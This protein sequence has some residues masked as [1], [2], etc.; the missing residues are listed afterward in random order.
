MNPKQM[1]RITD[2]HHFRTD[3]KIQKSPDLFVF[4]IIVCRAVI[5]VFIMRHHLFAGSAEKY[6]CYH[7]LP[8]RG[9]LHFAPS[10]VPRVTAPFSI[11]FI[12]PVPD[13]SLDA[14]GNLLRDIAGRNQMLCH[15]YIIVLY[16]H[17]FQIWRKPPDH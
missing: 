4:Y 11:N 5:L 1:I 8:V 15:R 16:H 12:F 6:R 17:N 9:F 2:L 10:S 7:H 13:A 14:K 3:D